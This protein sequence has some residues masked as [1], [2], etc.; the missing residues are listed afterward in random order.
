MSF[1]DLLDSEDSEVT[2]DVAPVKTAAQM[3]D[4][5]TFSELKED[6]LLYGIS[7]KTMLVLESYKPT[8]P[9]NITIEMFTTANSNINVS[10]A[11]A[12]I[13]SILE[14]LK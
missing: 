8:L 2:A 6:I 10:Y 13:D 4:Y 1:R 14:D 5:K 3:E 12:S 9:D 7:Q 11:L